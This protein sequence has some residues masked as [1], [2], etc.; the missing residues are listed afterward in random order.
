[1]QNVVAGRL[2]SVCN[3]HIRE[4]R[5]AFILVKM[6]LFFFLPGYWAYYFSA[7]ITWLTCFFFFLKANGKIEE[8]IIVTDYFYFLFLSGKILLNYHTYKDSYLFSLT[9]TLPCAPVSYYDLAIVIPWG[10]RIW[11]S[12]SLSNQ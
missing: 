2:N 7:G 1:M 5:K 10:D 4:D 8:K 6:S 9:L 3:L 12:L 11:F